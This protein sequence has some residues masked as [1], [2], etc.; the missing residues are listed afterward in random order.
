MIRIAICDDEQTVCALLQEHVSQYMQQADEPFQ[1]KC[2]SNALQL[3]HAPAP[4][5]ILLL[6]IQMPGINGVEFARIFRE[7][8][9]HT[10]LIFIT[11]LQEYVFDAF[12]VN[13]IDYICKPIDV[14]RLQRALARAVQSVHMSVPKHLLVQTMNTCRSVAIDTIYYCEVIN[15][16]IY[17]HTQN[18]VVDYYG[19]LAELATQLDSRFVQCHRSYL[20]NLD[21]L[22]Q[23]ESGRVT[24]KNG[25]TLPVSRLRHHEFMSA[26]MQYMKQNGG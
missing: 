3:L 12:E 26:I 19:K 22:A 9:S 13:A 8:H 1:I 14:D 24:L 2:F 7:T 17:L 11:G 15:R 21:Y 5:D 10:A 25:E 6:D 23:Y 16:K 18:G 4:F 20:V